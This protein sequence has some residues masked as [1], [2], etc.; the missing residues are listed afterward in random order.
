MKVKVGFTTG[1]RVTYKAGTERVPAVVT[2][3]IADSAI[4]GGFEY[5]IRTTS[6]RSRTYVKG[7]TFR[8]TGNYL[9]VGSNAKRVTPK[10][11]KRKSDNKEL[12]ALKVLAEKSMR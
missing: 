10:Q 7:S 9:T 4:P 3:V 6:A 8:T 2:S 5:E 1:M 12:K 11:D